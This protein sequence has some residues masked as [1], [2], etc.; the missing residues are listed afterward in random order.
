MHVRGTLGAGNVGLTTQL[1]ADLTRGTHAYSIVQ[2]KHETS[3]IGAT[4]WTKYQL[5]YIAYGATL[6]RLAIFL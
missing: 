5:Q 4:F 2:R 1:S 6:I 3:L